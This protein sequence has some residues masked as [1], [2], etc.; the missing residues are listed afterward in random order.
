[1]ADAPPTCPTCK[2]DL[3]GLGISGTCPECGQ[4]FDK[5][6]LGFRNQLSRFEAKM[7]RIRTIALVGFASFTLAL[8]TL[9]QFTIWDQGL[10]SASLIALPLGMA[11]LWSFLTEKPDNIEPSRIEPPDQ[12]RK[13]SWFGAKEDYDSPDDKYEEHFPLPKD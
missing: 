7:A 5:S 2:Y 11:A 3:T 4:I 12:N 8:G 6:R 10:A 13:K 9:L 1:M